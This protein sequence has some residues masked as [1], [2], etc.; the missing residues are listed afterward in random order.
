M[1]LPTSQAS[2]RGSIVIPLLLEPLEEET[3]ALDQLQ[4][5]ATGHTRRV[6]QGGVGGLGKSAA[7]EDSW[8]NKSSNLMIVIDSV[9]CMKYMCLH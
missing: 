6:A 7:M 9:K 3:V 5:P 2:R 1:V 4:A 8:R